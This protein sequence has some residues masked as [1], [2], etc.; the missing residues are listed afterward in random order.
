MLLHLFPKKMVTLH[1]V[2]LFYDNLVD[3]HA[4]TPNSTIPA[5]IHLDTPTV[6]IH[7]LYF[8]CRFTH[9][10]HFCDFSM[11]IL[12]QS[13]LLCYLSMLKNSL[14]FHFRYFYEYFRHFPNYFIHPHRIGRI[15][16][17]QLMLSLSKNASSSLLYS[18]SRD[19]QLVNQ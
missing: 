5:K 1:V 4:A 12:H 3:L 15:F 10:S 6:V 2:T 7:F 14:F 8:T 11:L 19:F 9:F 13:F 16:Y 17:F 18:T